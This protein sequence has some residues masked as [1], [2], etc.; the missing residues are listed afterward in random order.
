MYFSMINSFNGNAAFFYF[1][2]QDD[3]CGVFQLIKD[4]LRSGSHIS[5][6][7]FTSGT[8]SGE[9]STARNE[10]SI[11]I[12]SKIGVSRDNI[13]FFGSEYK[14]PDCGLVDHIDF[15]CQSIASNLKLASSDCKIYIPA[16]EGGHPDHDALHAA[17]VMA[18][19][20]NNL[21]SKTYQY[22]L[23]N[24]HKCFG[25][26]F[27]VLSPLPE[28][29]AAFKSP[30]SIIN[31]MK[32]LGYCLRYP[33]QLK[34]WIG[35]FPFF[36]LHYIFRGHQTWQPVS[37]QRI[38]ELPH[39]GNLYFVNRGFANKRLFYSKINKFLN[40]KMTIKNSLDVMDLD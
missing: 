9:L 10:E 35:L 27:R 5:C 28:N 12:L 19:K 21:L 25:P 13:H 11:N 32:F 39:Q 22:A 7:Y 8:F 36:F 2:H 4:E 29:G 1:A 17:V 34:S 33:S 6:F 26:M 14:I 40:E 30:I 20:E 18:V 16:W 38:F 23:Y 37:V 3:E 24:G 31:R 15:V